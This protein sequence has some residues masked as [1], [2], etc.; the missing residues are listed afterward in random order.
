[1]LCALKNLLHRPAIR[2][3]MAR[4]SRGGLRDPRFVSF[5][6]Q[7]NHKKLDTN[8]HDAVMR[9]RRMLRYGLVLLVAVGFAWVV[10]ESAKALSVF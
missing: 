3:G 4:D 7:N 1:M 5:L 8:F 2:M 6:A 9:G 10:I